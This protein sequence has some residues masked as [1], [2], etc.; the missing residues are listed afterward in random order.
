MSE[1]VHHGKCCDELLMEIG[2]YVDGTLPADLCVLLEQHLAGCPRCRLVVDTTRKTIALYHETLGSV[3][4]PEEIR[5]RLFTCLNLEEYLQK[6]DQ[7]ETNG[8]R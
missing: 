8:A 2:E 6:P 5:Q 3:E 7:Q 1:H 4:L